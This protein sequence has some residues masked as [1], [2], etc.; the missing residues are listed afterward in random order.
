LA[1]YKII[2]GTAVFLIFFSGTLFV[3]D[4]NADNRVTDPSA[5]PDGEKI[6]LTKPFPLLEGHAYKAA[7][8]SLAKLSDSDVKLFYSPASLCED[9]EVLGPPHT[10]HVE[11][12]KTGFGRFS[13]FGDSVI[14][15]SSDNSDPNSN[16]RQYAI[17]VPS[18][19]R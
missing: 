10:F 14:F 8:P 5:C 17:V 2:G 6:F 11:I 1:V 12:A 3:L 16:G 4:R 9:N 15:S 19:G 13:H 18:D 7:L